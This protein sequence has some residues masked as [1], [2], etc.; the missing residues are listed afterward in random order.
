MQYLSYR[1][2]FHLVGMLVI[3]ILAIWISAHLDFVLAKPVDITGA[4]Q[5]MAEDNSH[6][7]R[8]VPPIRGKILS[9]LQKPSGTILGGFLLEN[10]TE[11]NT[12]LSQVYVSIRSTTK[13]FE[14]QA[15]H[16]QEVSS[17]ALKVGQEVQIQSKSVLAQSYPPQVE[18]SVVIIFRA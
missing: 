6:L 14:K 15:T 3:A 18:A 8:V 17:D 2:I 13:F 12:A 4:N 5:P 10:A 11:K 16:Y 1:K 7:S 9:I